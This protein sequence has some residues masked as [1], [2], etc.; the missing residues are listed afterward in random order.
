MLQAMI[1]SV[2][3]VQGMQRVLLVLSWGSEVSHQLR[4]TN[5]EGENNLKQDENE[6]Q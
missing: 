5:G 2:L 4:E 6:L 1:N 3:V